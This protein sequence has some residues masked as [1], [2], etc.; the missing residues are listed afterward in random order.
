MAF[1]GNSSYA[2]ATYTAYSVAKA[3][4]NKWSDIWTQGFPLLG[5][6]ERGAANFNRGF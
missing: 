3:V 5:A 1:T 4:T 2:I 6:I